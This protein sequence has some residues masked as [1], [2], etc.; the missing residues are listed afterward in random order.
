MKRE[1]ERRQSRASASPR[2]EPRGSI[3]RYQIGETIGEGTF[4]KVKKGTHVLTGTPVSSRG[5]RARGAVE[6]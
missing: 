2:V 5:E 3:S 6:C 1:R 4:G